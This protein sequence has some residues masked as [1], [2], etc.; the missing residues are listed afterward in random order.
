MIGNKVAETGIGNRLRV[1]PPTALQ[2]AK[3]RDFS[4][5]SSSAFPLSLAAK[6]TFIHLDLAAEHGLAFGLQFNGDD[7]AQTKKVE[8]RCFTVARHTGWTR[9]EPSCPRQNAQS[10]GL[11]YICSDGSCA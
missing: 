1:N 5:G 8:G 6:I 9:F 4:S 7:F 3:Y 2:Q 11:V 10:N